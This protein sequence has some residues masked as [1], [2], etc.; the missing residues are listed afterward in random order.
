MRDKAKLLEE[1]EQYEAQIHEIKTAMST[2]KHHIRWEQLPDE[3]KF[4]SL[5]PT[6]RRL[7]DTIRMI[8]YPGTDLCMHDELVT[9]TSANE[10]MVSE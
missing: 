6:R 5:A 3:G 9:E 10:K 1:I 4:H 7:M 8:A 2:T